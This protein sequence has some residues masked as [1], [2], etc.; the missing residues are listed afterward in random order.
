M[1]LKP[2][3]SRR[4]NRGEE[5]LQP[6]SSH[7]LHMKTAPCPNKKTEVHTF[8][9]NTG[10]VDKHVITNH[11][12]SNSD[13]HQSQAHTLPGRPSLVTGARADKFG[14]SFWGPEIPACLHTTV[15]EEG[16]RE[17]AQSKGTEGQKGK[18]R[19]REG[20]LREDLSHKVEQQGREM[21]REEER[22]QFFSFS[23]H[24]F[25]CCLMLFAGFSIHD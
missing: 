9:K 13:V 3:L 16:E 10:A 12:G 2:E 21:E 17:R 8:A 14:L 23:S 24:H 7:K 6:L 4:E 22:D 25:K 5:E 19:K 11:T 20:V 18:K 1:S 15:E